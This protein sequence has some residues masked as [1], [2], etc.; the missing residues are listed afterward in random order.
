MSDP[1]RNKL[2]PGGNLFGADLRKA[3]LTGANL[4]AAKLSKADLRGAD[5]READLTA[6]KLSKA[7]LFGADLFGAKLSGADLFGADLFGADLSGADL[8]GTNLFGANLFG[9]N[10]RG[11]ICDRFTRWP[12]SAVDSE[13]FVLSAYPDLSDYRAQQVAGILNASV[14][15]T[16]LTGKIDWAAVHEATAAAR[17]EI[18][19][20][21]SDRLS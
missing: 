6:A 14:M 18:F 8:R 16:R 7:D 11:A 13:P 2:R 17:R 19:Q 15:R 4:I 12:L 5:L 10:L 21:D 1:I 20:D 9:A 3:D